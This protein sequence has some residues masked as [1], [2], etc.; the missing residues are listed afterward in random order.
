MVPVV[1]E[2]DT[3]ATHEIRFGDNDRLAA[4]VAHLV[5]ANALVLLSDVE[6]LFTANPAKPGAR[7]INEVRSEADLA[8][9]AIETRGTASRH[10]GMVTKIDAARIATSAGIHVVLTTAEQAEAALAGEPVGTLFHPTGRRRPTRPALWLRQ[11]QRRSRHLWSWMPG[12]SG[13][14]PSAIARCSQPAS[15]R[16]TRPVSPLA[17]R[18]SWSVPMAWLSPVGW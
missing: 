1:N 3:V 14:S 5:H 8:D 2:N 7:K 9:V 12:L 10:W 15:P 16:G 13:R 4:L 17:S 6:A 18:W 11:C